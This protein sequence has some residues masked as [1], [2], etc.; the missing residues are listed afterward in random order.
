MDLFYA[1][2]LSG[3]LY[4]L[5]EEESKHLI[6]VLRSKHG[7]HLFLTDGM[8]T[9]AEAVIEDPSPKR[10]LVR[11]VS[12][13]KEGTGRDFHLHIAIAPTKN[14]DRFEWFLEK[15]TEIGIDEVTPLI[16]EHSERTRLNIERLRKVMI[17][18]MKQ[19][20][21]AWLPALNEPADFG[22]LVGRTFDGEKYI[23]YCGE[24]ELVSLK[25]VHR[26]GAKTLILIGPEGDFSEKEVMK[27]KKEGFI[28]I[29]LGKS[30]LRTET[31]GIVACHT[32]NFL[33]SE[34]AK[35]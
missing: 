25:N 24:E 1:H 26:K 33:N 20:L 14:S 35:T 17:A 4:T 21:K 8:G 28:P 31:A 18:A 13:W 32:I 10:C 22:K 29:T 30:R 23:A 6:R 27:A 9:L 5:P 12:A 3:G 34:V 19:S 11:I 15:S 7:D 2:D 16:C